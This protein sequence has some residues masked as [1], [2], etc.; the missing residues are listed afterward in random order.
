MRSV[1][2]ALALS[3]GSLVHDLGE[4]VG[5]LAPNLVSPAGRHTGA[6]EHKLMI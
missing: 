1:D 4:I 6:S 2:R 5:Q 3:R